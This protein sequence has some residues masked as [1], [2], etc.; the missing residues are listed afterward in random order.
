MNTIIGREWL[1]EKYLPIDVPL[2]LGIK[3]YL[4]SEKYLN[5]SYFDLKNYLS[6]CSSTAFVSIYKIGIKKN[7]LTLLGFLFH[8]WIM[9][10][11]NSN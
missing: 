8:M 2:M 3:D 5:I 11:F 9:E 4:Y 7:N 10:Y 1:R 6:E